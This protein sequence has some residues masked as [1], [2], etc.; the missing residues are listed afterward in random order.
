MAEVNVR[1]NGIMRRI[2]VHRPAAWLDIL[3]LT[4]MPQGSL[5]CS[6]RKK[7]T[8][9]NIQAR[10]TWAGLL[11]L[12]I[13]DKNMDYLK[14][15]YVSWNQDRLLCFPAAILF[16]G[17][18]LN[19]VHRNTSDRPVYPQQFLC[20]FNFMFSEFYQR[21]WFDALYDPGR[22]AELN[23]QKAGWSTLN[24]TQSTAWTN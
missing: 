15:S 19:S 8:G 1:W 20:S 7:L 23:M 14:V 18:V 11:I 3:P 6:L 16:W 13:N 22:N 9:N 10:R 2:N 24:K 5:I 4:P 12:F 21:K 17:V